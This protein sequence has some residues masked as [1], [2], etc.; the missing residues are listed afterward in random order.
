MSNK[1]LGKLFLIPNAMGTDLISVVPK[2]NLTLTAQI[3]FFIVESFKFGRSAIR[4]SGKNP[5]EAKSIELL[6]EHTK[7][8][9]LSALLSP[10]LQ[11]NNIGLISDAGCPAVADPGAKLVELA[12]ELN[13]SVEPLVGPNSILLSLMASGFNGQQFTFNG[14]LPKDQKERNRALQRLL[15]LAQKGNTQLFMETPYRNEKLLD[16]IIATL[17][18]ETKLSISCNLT[19]PDGFSK[20]KSLAFWK[21]NKPDI[22]KKPCIFG[23]GSTLRI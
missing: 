12:H 19:L 8:E 6:N 16:E 9:E 22:H 18:N 3:D 20:T 4:Q 10:A 7:I 15:Q 2:S 13:I 23:L 5:D 11:G 21:N 1:N 17:P 14:Y